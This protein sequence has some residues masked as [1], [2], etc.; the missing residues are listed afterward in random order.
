M[1]IWIDPQKLIGFNLTPAD[2]NAAISAQ[3][4]QVSAGQHR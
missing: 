4:A 1:R 2:V 3:N